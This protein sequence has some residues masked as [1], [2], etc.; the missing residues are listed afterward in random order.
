ME[1]LENEAEILTR[2]EQGEGLQTI[3]GSAQA[4]AFRRR[5]TD[6]VDGLASRYARSR[7]IGLDAIAEQIVEL[8]DTC[9]E[10]VKTERKQIGW[11]CSACT[12]AVSWGGRGW[13][14]GDDTDLCAAA[15]AQRV[16]EEKT[17]TGDMVERAKLQLDARKWLL[18]KL[19]PDKY[20]DR[21][22]VDAR[23]EHSAGAEILA[24]LRQR[25]G[26]EIEEPP[27]IEAAIQRED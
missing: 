15:T 12:R 3:C 10:G 18:S 11:Q 27:A 22:A 4:A 13:L 25:R 5:V 19:R 20:G 24:A 23:V 6:D 14:H 2:L 17:V 26:T 16:Y 8:A 21:L 9:R 7:N 1:P